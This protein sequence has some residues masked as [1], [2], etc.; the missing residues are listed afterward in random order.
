MTVALGARTIL[1]APTRRRV[2]IGAAAPIEDEGVEVRSVRCQGANA[3]YVHDRRTETASRSQRRAARGSC[4]TSSM[5][6]TALR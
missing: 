6:Y 2:G 1:C 5:S 4:D 3:A